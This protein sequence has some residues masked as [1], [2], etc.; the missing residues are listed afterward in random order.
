MDIIKN[1]HDK[2]FKEIMGDVK[3]AKSFLENYLPAEIIN[4]VDLE[5]LKPEKDSFIEKEL[6][7]IYSDL[8]FNTKINNKDGYLYFLF[9]H[10]SYIDKRVGVQLLKY[11]IS[12]WEQKTNKE[13]GKKLPVV[14]PIVIYQGKSEWNKGFTLSSQIEGYED[15]PDNIKR[16]VPDFLY[17]LYDFSKPGKEEIRG[18]LELIIYLKLIKIIFIEGHEEFLEE[19]KGITRLYEKLN[20]LKK[21]D[22]FEKLM[23]YILSAREDVNEDDIKRVVEEVSKEGS[24]VVMTAAERLINEGVQKGKQEGI[25]EEKI[26]TAKNMIKIGMDDDQIKEVTGLL[27]KEIKKLRV[28]K[29]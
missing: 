10:K 5:K 22:F 11:I 6:K 29:I 14:I 1:V 28:S 7:D 3:T 19:I 25:Q 9:E 12:I 13:K 16:Y 23:M 18:T 17:N 21:R 20:I 4:L 8:L 24:E 2:C 27:I 15:L 26:K